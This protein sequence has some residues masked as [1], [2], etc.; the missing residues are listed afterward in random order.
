MIVTVGIW[1][2]ITVCFLVLGSGI[3]E[4]IKRILVLCQDNNSGMI[5]TPVK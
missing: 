3:T 2:Y 1:I 5:Y 4:L